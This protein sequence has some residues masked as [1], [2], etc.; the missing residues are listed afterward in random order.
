MASMRAR[1]STIG[2]NAGWVGTSST[3]S[4]SIHTDRPSRIDSRYSSPVRITAPPGVASRKVGGTSGGCRVAAGR[5]R[6]VPSRL[7]LA[8]LGGLRQDDR[9]RV[10]D[11]LACMRLRRRPVAP[12]QRVED[13]PVALDRAPVLVAVVPAGDAVVEVVL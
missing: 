4:P 10:V 6:R 3:R 2:R 11:V 5:R 9:E 8:T 1:T 12:G 7:R 13:Q